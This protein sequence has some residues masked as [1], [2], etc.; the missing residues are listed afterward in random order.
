MVNF[1][2]SLAK[3][4]HNTKADTAHKGTKSD[5]AGTDAHDNKPATP[6]K[7]GHDLHHAL[8]KHP[9]QRDAVYKRLAHTE[10]ALIHHL[11]QWRLRDEKEHQSGSG[12]DKGQ[13]PPSAA[14]ALDRLRAHKDLR[15]AFG[16]LPSRHQQTVSNLPLKPRQ[17]GE[18][19][20]NALTPLPQWGAQPWHGRPLSSA[21]TKLTSLVD[22][23]KSHAGQLLGIHAL[24]SKPTV[25]PREKAVNDATKEVNAIPTDERAEAIER[26]T[27]E[28][29]QRFGRD[30]AVAFVSRVVITD[31]EGFGQSVAI[32]DQQGDHFDENT[33]AILAEG[34]D[35]AYADV[36][37]SPYTSPARLAASLADGMSNGMS[38]IAPIPSTLLPEIVG[39][40]GN[41]QLQA[42][43]VSAGLYR[44]LA[45]YN[46]QD[47]TAPIYWGPTAALVQSLGPATRDSE[48]AAQAVID[49][50]ERFDVPFTSDPGVRGPGSLRAILELFGQSGSNNAKGQTESGFI[51]FM[52]A[53]TGA[54]GRLSNRQSLTLF[55][56]VAGDST[57]GVGL[58]E[59]D[60]PGG[61]HDTAGTALTA[62]LFE[63]YFARWAA[64]DSLGLVSEGNILHTGVPG[65]PYAGIDFN[66][67]FQ[68]FVKEALLDPNEDGAYREQLL[69]F[70]AGTVFS[71]FDPNSPLSRALGPDAAATLAG[72]LLGLLETSQVALY[73]DLRD[74]SDQQQRLLTLLAVV[75]VAAGGA[76]LAAQ[77]TT[78]FG[79]VVVA[80][81]V[82]A[83][84]SGGRITAEV[85]AAQGLD[86]DTAA[87]V[88]GYANGDKTITDVFKQAA[89]FRALEA[90][91]LGEKKLLAFV[92]NIQSTLGH[93]GYT[94]AEAIVDAINILDNDLPQAIKDRLANIQKQIEQGIEH[95]RKAA[96]E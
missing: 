62:Q 92:Q 33:K 14:D 32:Y 60:G 81:L 42:D 21:P 51:T 12:A 22:F 38:G 59:A 18:R 66:R 40:T 5:K 15:D 90:V 54:D 72:N 30:T 89:V 91:G 53:A 35:K 23:I 37:N 67:A 26:K 95:Q 82:E 48:K 94:L 19:F 73:G 17:P 78:T 93:G 50:A 64:D 3:L 20:D 46:A 70:M 86:K 71:T 1:S 88:A 29:E 41:E 6:S 87:V 16:H 75:S 43:F 52:Q 96:G 58:I 49:F 34:I 39:L 61:S 31:P 47:S 2:S 25:D 55:L 85:L 10:P 8:K 11:E 9:E 36:P 68:T 83:G 69:G 77:A 45:N 57:D 79:R 65:S 28:L 44:A 7:P 56:A 76:G 80:A 24:G 4:N 13:A 63:Q 27:N 74:A 84:K